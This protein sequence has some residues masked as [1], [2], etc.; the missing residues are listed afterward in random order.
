MKNEETLHKI[1]F[2]NAT[3]GKEESFVERILNTN[4]LVLMGFVLIIILEQSVSCCITSNMPSNDIARASVGTEHSSLSSTS[5]LRS[6]RRRRKNRIGTRLNDAST[7]SL[8][9]NRSNETYGGTLRRDFQP[10]EPLVSLRSLGS[11]TSDDESN[12]E[13]ANELEHDQIQFRS[14]NVRLK[15]A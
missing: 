2:P 7:E 15:F 6:K 11:T 3:E 8:V 10:F 14:S 12:R 5:S 4:V 1:L 9:L 13:S